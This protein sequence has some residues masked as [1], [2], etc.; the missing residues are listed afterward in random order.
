MNQLLLLLLLTLVVTTLSTLLPVK[1]HKYKPQVTI[2]SEDAQE[3]DISTND[4]R[5][6]DLELNQSSGGIENNQQ[7]SFGSILKDHEQKLSETHN[8]KDI[9]VSD[10][11]RHEKEIDKENHHTT[12][13][14]EEN[15]H[16]KGPDGEQRIYRKTTENHHQ[17]NVVVREQMSSGGDILSSLPTQ[18]KVEDQHKILLT[19]DQHTHKIL[20]DNENNQKVNEEESSHLVHTSQFHHSFPDN[21]N[22]EQH[23]TVL[24]LEKHDHEKDLHRHSQIDIKNDNPQEK[25]TFNNFPTPSTIV[26]NLSVRDVHHQIESHLH[27]GYLDYKPKPK[28]NKIHVDQHQASIPS[29]IPPREFSSNV[30]KKTDT[31]QVSLQENIGNSNKEIYQ[32]TD[33]SKQVEIEQKKHSH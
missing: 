14:H 12:N 28:V 30:D 1:G 17:G 18:S 13:T 26:P 32:K 29:Y 24:T 19:D 21:V 10:N 25:I 9:A 6:I 31:T 3:S 8:H 22:N 16:L 20:E 23:K 33:D 27:P 2:K 4:N 15:H 11:S 5:K 7:T